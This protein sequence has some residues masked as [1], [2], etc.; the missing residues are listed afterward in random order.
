MNTKKE[1]SYLKPSRKG[2]I[3]NLEPSRKGFITN[4]PNFQHWKKVAAREMLDKRPINIYLHIPFCIQRCA[5]CYYRTTNLKG[6][7]RNERIA[8][9]VKA[10]CREIEL[11]AQH[12]DLKK[13]DVASIYFGGGTPSLLNESQFYSIVETLHENLNIN[14]IIRNT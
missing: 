11:A 3:T 7:E 4:Y 1:D 12:F 14:E 2:F 10:I 5:Y 9:Y 6:S 8:S 13:R